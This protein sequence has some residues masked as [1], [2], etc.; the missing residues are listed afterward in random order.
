MKPRVLIIISSGREAKEKAM[1]GLMYATNAVKNGWADVRLIFFGPVEDLIA[2]NDPD[3]VSMIE[4]FSEISEKPLACRRIAEKKNY[5]EKIGEK[6]NV[7]YV[8]SIISRLIA[9]GY[10]PLVF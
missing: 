1:T 7:V 10:I 4:K 3:I 6:V 9:D 8:G 2:E 5:A